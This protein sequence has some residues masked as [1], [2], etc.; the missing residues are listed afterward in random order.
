M[1]GF[2]CVIVYIFYTMEN[3]EKNND[4]IPTSEKVLLIIQGIC[5]L[6]FFGWLDLAFDLENISLFSII[7]LSVTGGIFVIAHLIYVIPR[8]KARRA[9]KRYKWN[10]MNTWP[11]DPLEDF[12]KNPFEELDK[13]PFE[14]LDNRASDSENKD[15]QE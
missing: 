12:D 7:F 1:I 2:F 13:N 10:D 4:L 8:I 3:K 9:R 6:L 11:S 5:L 15:E 14:E